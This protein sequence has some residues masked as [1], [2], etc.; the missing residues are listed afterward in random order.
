[1]TTPIYILVFLI[2]AINISCN[3]GNSDL[4]SDWTKSESISDS[5][6]HAKQA[7]CIS[8]I[9]ST[10]RYFI[11]TIIN[12]NK[13][14]GG[15]WYAVC[16]TNYYDSIQPDASAIDTLKLNARKVGYYNR[17][18]YII[19]LDV[20]WARDTFIDNHKTSL[21]GNANVEDIRSMEI[22]AEGSISKYSDFVS[23]YNFAKLQ[24]L[25]PEKYDRDLLDTTFHPSFYL[26]LTDIKAARLNNEK[27]KKSNR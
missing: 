22:T 4:S 18:E 20:T 26:A 3:S 14:E 8:F 24:R 19:G 15:V 6:L 23:S 13:S 16:F 11:G 5:E 21:L 7:D 9:D 25:F 17:K 2:L 27:L 10:G 1:M 12:F